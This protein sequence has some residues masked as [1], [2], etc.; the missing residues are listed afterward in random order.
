M[1]ERNGGIHKEG[2]TG[3]IKPD[4]PIGTLVK[5][6]AGEDIEELPAL[7]EH[8]FEQNGDQPQQQSGREEDPCFA[9]ALTMMWC[10]RRHFL[11]AP[12]KKEACF[13]EERSLL[14]WSEVYA[15]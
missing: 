6:T 4:D 10:P 1:E 7:V 15:R 8:N 9:A 2:I 14:C 3:D 12:Q 11:L 13:A 5:A